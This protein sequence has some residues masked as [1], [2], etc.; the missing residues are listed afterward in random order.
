MIYLIVSC[1]NF[2]NDLKYLINNKLSWDTLIYC[3]TIRFQLTDVSLSYF[4]N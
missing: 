4:K 2:L 3:L 1:D